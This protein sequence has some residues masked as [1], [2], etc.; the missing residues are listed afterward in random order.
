MNGALIQEKIYYGYNLA[1]S[2]LGF[3]Y[4]WYRPS[5]ANNPLSGVNLLAPVSISYQS[6]VLTLSGV[7]FAGQQIQVSIDAAMYSY[8]VSPSDTMAS[9]TTGLGAV[10][11]SA[12]YANTVSGLSITF[13]TPP[14][15]YIVGSSF[16]LA[17]M[18]PNFQYSTYVGFGKFAY[19]CLANGTIL[20]VGDFL[21]GSNRIFYIAALQDLLPIF[22]VETNDTLSVLRYSTAGEV[23]S[24]DYS[25]LTS[26][27]MVIA[28]QWPCSVLK[29]SRFDP[30]PT[31]LP[32]GSKISHM[33]VLMP[34]PPGVQLF[35]GDILQDSSGMKYLIDMIELTPLGYRLDCSAQVA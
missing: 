17:S 20:E 30:D 18:T 12:G 34:V 6:P 19:N 14:A 24:L 1:A 8:N 3:P 28:A 29:A 27:E 26:S 15:G 4:A 9:V 13:T 5:G 21:V 23:G 2:R 22:A 32:S 7:P 31:K 33:Q 10:L 16:I 11:S 35:Y 25:G